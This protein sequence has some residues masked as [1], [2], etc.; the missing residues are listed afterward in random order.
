MAVQ[1]ARWLNNTCAQP[2]IGVIVGNVQKAFADK[3]FCRILFIYEHELC[4]GFIQVL[5]SLLHNRGIRHC[6]TSLNLSLLTRPMAS[7]PSYQLCLA[8]P[9]DT[10]GLTF[11]RN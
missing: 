7:A 4:L 11:Q 2:L 6:T 3:I 8:L 5:Q 1:I 10:C 9:S